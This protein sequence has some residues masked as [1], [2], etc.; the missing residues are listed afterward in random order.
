MGLLHKLVHILSKLDPN[1][2]KWKAEQ[3]K[4]ITDPVIRQEMEDIFKENNLDYSRKLYLIQNCIYGVDIQPMATQI[5]RLRFFI[6]LIVD[7]KVDKTKDNFGIYALPNLETKFVAANTLI[8]LEAKEQECSLFVGALDGLKVELSE[9]RKQY[10][11][12]RR[13]E[14][15]KELREKDKELRDKIIEQAKE[16]RFDIEKTT[17]LVSWNPYAKDIASKW[18]DPKWMFN[19]EE[20]DIVI[21]NPPYGLI[22]KRQN[23]AETI[24]VNEEDYDFYKNSDKYS[25]ATTGGINVFRLFIV[26]SLEL[27]KTNGS[28]CEIFPLAFVADLSAKKLRENILKNHCITS[29]EAFPER[30]NEAKRVFKS[31]KISACI[32]N[33]QKGVPQKEF[34]IR[35][36]E[37][38]Y[39]EYDKEK[40]CLDYKKI[41]LFDSVYYTIPLLSN[42]DITLLSKV[43]SKGCKLETFAHC[44]TGEIDLSLNADLLSFDSKYCEMIKGAI[45][46]R[47]I[48]RKKMSQ[49][50][51]MYLK[52]SEYLKNNTSKKSRHHCSKRIVMQ[53]ITGVNEKHRLKMTIIPEGIY[54][55]N[56]VNY[57][58]FDDTDENMYSILGILNSKLLDYIFKKFST[59]SNV[60]GYEVDALPI[61]ISNENIKNSIAEKVVSILDLTKTDNYEDSKQ[62]QRAVQE[63]ESQIDIMVYKLYELTYG[64]VKTI[65]SDF[66]MSEEEYNQFNL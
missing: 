59:N 7:E 36:N 62:R 42:E 49:G 1:N 24:V 15:K 27:L 13:R 34:F 53:G 50:E 23:K 46:D 45:I 37:E 47:Y 26:R 39:V 28:F 52:E 51:I 19:V 57:I 25:S 33:I 29:I 22:N 20:F 40:V 58:V 38:P 41:Q 56:S 11:N 30:D 17:Q 43:F 55:A 10:F 21:G 18:F 64:E 8:S 32:T 2:N 35:M 66:S 54:C 12:A 5:S 63:Y 4:N 3:L 60:N 6:S 48:K 65:D 44:Y 14:Q 31:A 61:C 16:M 9:C